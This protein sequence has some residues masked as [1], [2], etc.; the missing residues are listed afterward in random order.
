MSTS[1]E[2]A[3]EDCDF[4]DWAVRIVVEVDADIASGNPAQH[5]SEASTKA[6]RA[7][8]PVIA[9]YGWVEGKPERTK[10]RPW[11][12]ERKS[13]SASLRVERMRQA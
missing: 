2:P 9:V 5:Q 6:I 7:H 3:I 4:E 8:G 10:H 11:T 1:A 13:S 12:T